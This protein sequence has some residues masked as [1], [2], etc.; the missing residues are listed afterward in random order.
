MSTMQGSGTGDLMNDA[1][2]ASILEKPTDKLLKDYLIV[3]EWFQ[4]HMEDVKLEYDKRD[5]LKKKDL[6][7][8]SRLLFVG[9]PGT[10][11]TIMSRYLADELKMPFY[12]V[13]SDRMVH[14][15]YGYEE[16]I[17]GKLW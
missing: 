1:M 16:R 6:K 13:R 12:A 8:A 15:L 10:G 14:S 11:K 3:P 17:M 2:S 4:S 7:N 5:L 9:P